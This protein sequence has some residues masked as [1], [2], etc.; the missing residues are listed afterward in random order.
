MS[1]APGVS[2]LPAPD[3]AVKSDNSLLCSKRVSGGTDGLFKGLVVSA[4]LM[5]SE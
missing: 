1:L 3:S 4:V 5:E 2:P